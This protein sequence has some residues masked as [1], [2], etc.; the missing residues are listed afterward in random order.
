FLTPA[1]ARHP[2][3]RNPPAGAL[4]FW[5]TGRRPGHVALSMGQGLIASNDIVRAG[6]IDVVALNEIER[7]WGAR[8][9]G[10]TAPDFP[11]AG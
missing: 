4:V 1:G 5:D 6:R 3:D 10:W 7:R 8:Y 9:L 11:R 2:G